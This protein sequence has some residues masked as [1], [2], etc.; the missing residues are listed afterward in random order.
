MDTLACPADNP[1]DPQAATPYF[2]RRAAF[3]AEVQA[4]VARRVHAGRMIRAG[5]AVV[6]PPAARPAWGRA[7]A[8]APRG[9]KEAS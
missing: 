6:F 7:V 8:G 3:A 1:P 2:P 9:T 5:C 4:E